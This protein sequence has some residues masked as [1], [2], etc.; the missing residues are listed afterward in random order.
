MDKQLDPKAIEGM[1]T[2]RKEAENANEVFRKLERNMG[3]FTRKMNTANARTMNFAESWKAVDKVDTQSNK[4]KAPTA[5]KESP[6]NRVDIGTIR[7]DVSGVTDKT[8]KQKLAEDISA[9][10]S[11]ALQS[12]M[13]GPLSTGGYNRGM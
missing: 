3:N 4:Q 6:T 13:G 1:K 5:A 11:K 7:I 8:D 9:R 10:V 12:K 2:F